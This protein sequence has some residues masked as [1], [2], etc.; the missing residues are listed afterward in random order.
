M[1]RILEI[2]TRVCASGPVLKCELRHTRQDSLYQPRI[3]LNAPP[4]VP[5]FA[6]IECYPLNFMSNCLRK[7]RRPFDLELHSCSGAFRAC[8]ALEVHAARNHDSR[9]YRY[10]PDCLF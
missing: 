10:A 7:F 8:P 2:G 4:L 3:R 9:Q 1:T 5:D 6:R